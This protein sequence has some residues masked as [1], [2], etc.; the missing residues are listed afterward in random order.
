MKLRIRLQ[1][2]ALALLMLSFSACQKDETSNDTSLADLVSNDAEFTVFEAALNRAGLLNV[3][4]GAKLTVFAPTDAAFKAAGYPDAN[5]LS[6]ISNTA[7]V[8]ILQYHVVGNA[9]S[10]ADIAATANNAEQTTLTGTPLYISRGNGVISVNGAK[11]TRADVRTANGILHAIDKVLFPPEGNLA[12][13]VA[14]QPQLTYLVAA[15]NRAATD[16][17]LLAVTLQNG[18]P[19]TV[20]APTNQAFVNAGYKTIA[21]IQQA[22]AADIAKLLTYHLVRSRAFS[23]TFLNNQ[24]L[25]TEQGS[26]LKVGV[27]AGGITLLGN[28]NA[29]KTATVSEADIVATNGV[30]HLIDQVLIP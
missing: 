16:T 30:V 29:G 21:D 8:T 1:G 4:K 24:E 18:G 22:K 17:P 9:L 6:G 15:V 13:T 12:Q 25:N 28:G 10:S 14:A 26:K 5:A 23:T 11:V 2:W 3:L 20:F 27:T 7:L 19:F